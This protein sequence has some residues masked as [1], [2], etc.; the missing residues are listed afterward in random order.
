MPG[1][2]DHSFSLAVIC[3]G[4][5]SLG[6]MH[7]PL[8]A[9]AE[10]LAPAATLPPIENSAT[11]DASIDEV[12]AAWTTSEGVDDWL[13]PKA[14]VEPRP[15]G[16]FHAIFRPQESDPL[17]QGSIGEIIAIEQKKTLVLTWMTP[18]PM[19]ELRGN[20]TVLVAHFHEL[21]PRKTRIDI[22][23]TG[24][25]RGKLWQAA[26]DYN[27]KGWDRILSALEYRFKAG[28]INWDARIQEMR[29]TGTVSYWRENRK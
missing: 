24:Y 19:K 18:L 4:A 9:E 21:A 14:E 20:S 27:V 26:R 29:D 8:Q 15:R 12:W 13:S 3:A 6:M 22:I 10:L 16:K 7:T 2:S 25:G 5:L 11:I 17:D 28:P 1:L 23:N